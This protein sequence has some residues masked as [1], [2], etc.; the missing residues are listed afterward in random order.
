MRQAKGA[1]QAAVEP[2]QRE[3]VDES[4][5]GGA[6]RRQHDHAAGIGGGAQPAPVVGK[7]EIVGPGRERDDLQDRQQDEDGQQQDEA[8]PDEERQRLADSSA[9]WRGCHGAE[10]ERFEQLAAASH[11]FDAGL[12]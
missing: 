7:I 2:A 8:E 11:G 4:H 5:Q 1:A 10:R 6:R 3:G 12:A 9:P